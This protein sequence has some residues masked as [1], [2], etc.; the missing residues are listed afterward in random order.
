[1]SPYTFQMLL[2]QGYSRD[3][4]IH[5]PN[6]NLLARSNHHFDLT[7]GGVLEAECKELI[8]SFFRTKRLDPDLP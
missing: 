5:D 1:M 7:S 4:V 6:L 2:V 3:D 8:Q